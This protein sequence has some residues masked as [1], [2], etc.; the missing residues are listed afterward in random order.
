MKLNKH[1]AL[2]YN[3]ITYN[4]I[5]LNPFRN[6][7][8]W[9]FGGWMGHKFDD[10][11]RYLF[12]YVNQNHSDKIDSVWLT[13]EEVV[14]EQVRSLGYKS[15]LNK[16]KEGRRYQLKA[17]VAVYT[18]GLDDFGMF[19]LVGGAEIVSVWHGIGIKKLY[20]EKYSGKKLAVKKFLDFFFMWQQRDITVVSSQYVK[21]IYGRTFGLKKNA[22]Y[23]LTGQPRCDALFGLKKEEVLKNV[24]V[25]TSK[26]IILYMPT[27]RME[28][29][30]HDAIQNIFQALYDS[31][32]IDDALRATN[33]IIIAKPHPVSPKVEI[34][35]RDNFIILDNKAVESNQKLIGIADVLVTD[36][37]TSCIDFALLDRPILFYTPDEK[38]FI[39]KSEPLYDVYMDICRHNNCC[40]TA[41][42]LA[43]E[44]LNPTKDAVNALNDVY[45]DPITRDANNC[46]RV[47]ECIVK[48]VSI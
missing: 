38:E 16:S 42:E 43:K 36:Y 40:V 15:Y 8:I 19:P 11:S 41:E 17:G 4:L 31:K 37:S 21:E 47:Y 6:K 1:T 48:E 5:R 23:Y 30:G 28:S 39:E 20:N 10:N 45:N 33:S 25:D 32:E 13:D 22:K 26:R 14:V 18:H 9:V 29:L 35:N 3:I 34:E 27:Y 7:H 44:I 46:K 2:P 24:E 12:E